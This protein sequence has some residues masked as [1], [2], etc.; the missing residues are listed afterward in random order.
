VEDMKMKKNIVFVMLLLIGLMNVVPVFA[1]EEVLLISANQESLEIKGNVIEIIREDDY[2]RILVEDP[3]TKDRIYLN[4]G[5]ETKVINPLISLDFNHNY[6]EKGDRIFA[7][8]SPIMT[9]SLPAI[10]NAFEVQVINNVEKFEGTIE[11]VEDGRF[12]V[13]NGGYYLISMDTTMFVDSNNN[14]LEI[15][16]LEEGD[17]IEAYHSMVMAMSYPGQTGVY[18]IVK[19]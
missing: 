9:R 13:D 15:S 12:L 16:D 18:K 14:K 5:K 10:S 2:S 6:I 11:A 1:A 7:K 17:Q 3:I 8:Y 19:K 4:V